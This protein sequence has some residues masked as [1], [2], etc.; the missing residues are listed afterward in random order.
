[1]KE[2]YKKRF[3]FTHSYSDNHAKRESL[4]ALFDTVF[5]LSPEFLRRYYN[6]GYWDPS[7]NPFSFFDGEKAIANISVFEMPLVINGQ[8]VKAAGIQ[9]VMTHPEY[10]GKG[11]IRDLFAEIF[12]RYEPI[13][14]VFFLFTQIPKMYQRFGF[15]VVSQSHFIFKDIEKSGEKV[16]LVELDL[17]IK[18]DAHL[19][20]RLFD[21]RKP[22]S[23]VFGFLNHQNTFFFHLL[24]PSTKVKVAYLP[25]LDVA[26]AYSQ[27]DTV[28]HLYDVIG[29]QIPSLNLIC[30][31]F[32]FDISKVEI[33]FS[34]D[35]LN[36]TNIIMVPNQNSRLMVRGDCPKRDFFF[37][38]PPVAEF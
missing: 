20:N 25:T 10:R 33:Y 26:I 36:E 17:Q 6:N 2:R 32:E 13:Y 19:V 14:P 4:I 22:V 37:E 8:F 16:P 34:P 23:K 29:R 35:L 30:S 12:K 9:S 28:L 27:S 5:G 18:R 1:M 21:E 11:L 15:Q 7:Y 31:S 3:Y 24:N 38:I